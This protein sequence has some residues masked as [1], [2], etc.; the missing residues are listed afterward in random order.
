VF[1]EYL[2]NPAIFDHVSPNN[3]TYGYVK[4]LKEY[5]SGLPPPVITDN[6]RF[7]LKCE[8]AW[9]AIYEKEGMLLD[10]PVWKA[11]DKP[12]MIFH[13]GSSWTITHTQY[14][15]D[16][17]RGS[18]GF[19]FSDGEEAHQGWKGKVELLEPIPNVVLAEDQIQIRG[20]W[21]GVYTKGA[22]ILGKPTWRGPWLIFHNEN[23]WVITDP[24]YE[25]ELKK[26]SGGFAS[27]SDLISW[28]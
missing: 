14:E 6:S 9:S 8:D 22:E 7:F 4:V 1:K 23:S 11:V 16:L 28:T 27:S 19:V 21:A 2:K 20:R 13:N 25:A 26:G 5:A 10:Q 17:G 3:A 15:K 24:K 18:G 12:Y